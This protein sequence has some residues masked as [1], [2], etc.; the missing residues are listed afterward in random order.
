MRRLVL[1]TTRR[2]GRQARPGRQL[3]KSLGGSWHGTTSRRQV[4]ESSET[5]PSTGSFSQGPG[6]MAVTEAFLLSHTKPV[7]VRDL[8]Q[9]AK[10]RPATPHIRRFQASI[11]LP[12][13]LL[14]LAH[15]G[16]YSSG[17]TTGGTTQKPN[18][19]STSARKG[20]KSR[21]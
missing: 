21:R 12:P 8:N 18:S 7:S 10:K 6:H 20:P 13:A 19:T 5:L 3:R 15:T 4:R 16:F 17:F 2:G 9:T 14:F 1:A 11:A